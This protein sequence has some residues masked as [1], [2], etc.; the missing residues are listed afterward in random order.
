MWNIIISVIFYSI[1][2]PTWRTGLRATR[3]TSGHSGGVIVRKPLDLPPAVARA[4]GDAMNDYFT[5]SDKTK[6]DAIAA[7]QLSALQQYQ[8]PREKK[9]RLSDV[10]E[11][12]LEM[13]SRP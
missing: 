12:F 8:G 10:K 3:R 1:I 5:E 7:H 6:R 4:F 9:L 11:M 2:L 13:K